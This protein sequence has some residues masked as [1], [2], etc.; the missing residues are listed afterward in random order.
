[1]PS[2]HQAVSIQPLVFVLGT[3]RFLC[4]DTLLH[5]VPE[6]PREASIKIDALI[7]G[8]TNLHL[9]G[10]LPLVAHKSITLVGSYL[11]S[12]FVGIFFFV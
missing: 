8:S 10:L 6:P 2:P 5:N 9:S 1:M 12:V 3:M 11:F 4:A 7:V